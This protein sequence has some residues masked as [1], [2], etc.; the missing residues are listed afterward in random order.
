[1][2][3]HDRE[4]ALA[5]A[6]RDLIDAQALET[7]EQVALR[8]GLG[9]DPRADPA[10]RPPR[11]P[12][13]LR[14]RRLGR[15]DRQPGGLILEAAGEPRVVPSP[16]HRRDNH[17]MTAA[18]D[19]GRV[20]LQEAERGR[21][22]QRPPPPSTLTLIVARAPPPAMRAAILLAGS[23]PDRHDQNRL[24]HGLGGSGDHGPSVQFGD[25]EV[26]HRDEVAVGAVSASASFRGLDQRVEAFE[27][28]V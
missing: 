11:D 4:V 7:R 16:R 2:V 8:L 15:V 21:E 23:R 17:P 26:D 5:L 24:L 6:D 19:P 3:D 18:A 13:Q 10:D 12:H 9:G 14:H 22:I 25:D 27:Q 28:T 1:M 20:G